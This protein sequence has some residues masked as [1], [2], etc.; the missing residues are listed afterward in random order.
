MRHYVEAEVA[1]ERDDETLSVVASGHYV[2]GNPGRPNTWDGDGFAG[3]E[4]FVEDVRAEGLDG[5]VVDLDEWE[6]ELCEA[7]LLEAAEEEEY[8]D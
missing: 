5:V 1:L 4:A 6:L 2:P 7:A 8:Y 3:W